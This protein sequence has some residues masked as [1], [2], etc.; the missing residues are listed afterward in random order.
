M[1]NFMASLDYLFDCG[2]RSYVWLAI[3]KTRESF[4]AEMELEMALRLRADSLE[5]VSDHSC[6]NMTH[7]LCIGWGKNA[8][9]SMIDLNLLLALAQFL[10]LA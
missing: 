4:D 1:K 7:I 10:A 3:D 5:C 8:I 9:S 2:C 6:P